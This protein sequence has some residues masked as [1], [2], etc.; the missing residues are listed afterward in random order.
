MC[1]T[2]TTC[3]VV[4][5]VIWPQFEDLVP[6]GYRKL[7]LIGLAIPCL[8]PQIAFEIFFAKPFGVTA[9]A[10]SVDYEFTS[11]DY[12]FEFTMLNMNAQWVKVNGTKF[13]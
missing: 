13:N 6:K 9:Y 8:S 11:K 12:A 7:A 10:D 4:V 5:W 2:V 3:I 1:V